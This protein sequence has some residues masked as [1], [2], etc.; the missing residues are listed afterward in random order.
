MT[1]GQQSRRLGA[2]RVITS[3]DLMPRAQLE[4]T[5]FYRDW[6][7][8]LDIHSMVGAVFTLENDALGVIGVHRPASHSGDF[9]EHD[10]RRLGMLLPHLQRAFQL[11]QRLQKQHLERAAAS[12]WLD[13]TAVAVFV[14]SAKGRL[15]HANGRAEQLLRQQTALL[16]ADGR[17]TTGPAGPAADM[18]RQIA[19]AAHSAAG[20]AQRPGNA[21]LIPRPGEAPLTLL[22]APL[23]ASMAASAR[24]PQQPLV[25]LFAHDPEE[26]DLSPRT[27][28]ALFGLTPTEA[29]IAA[30]LAL[31]YSLEEASEAQDIGIGTARTHLKSAMA[32]T[33]THRQ[34]EMVSLLL[35]SVAPW[36]RMAESGGSADISKR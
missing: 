12:L 8:P 18:A 3:Q 33:G 1:C 31:G 16:V 22:I 34:A 15:V 17:L 27:L 2:N 4:N 25:A 24:L 21:L 11:R 10:R 19:A 20:R 7:R 36:S 13:R 29:R 32:K 9:D 30:A 5:G 23:S 14:V 28:Q 35:R 26:L 6:L